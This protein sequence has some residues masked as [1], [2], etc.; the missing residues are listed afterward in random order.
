MTENTTLKYTPLQ[1]IDSK[2]R[3]ANEYFHEKQLKL[4]KT[5]SPRKADLKIRSL[6]LKKLYYAIK[7]HEQ[8]I[9][10]AMYRDFHRSPTETTVLEI[11][12]VYNAILHI[13]DRLHIW[14]APKRIRDNSSPAFMFSKIVIEKIARGSALIIGPFNFPFFLSLLPVAYAISAGNSVILK[15]SELV[16]SC[17]QLLEEILYDADF[18]QGMVQV[19]QG[20]IPET[21]SLVQSGRFDL[22]FFTGAPKTGSIIAQEAAKSLTPCVLELGGKSPAFITETLE[23]KY[24]ETT[25]KRLFFSSFGNSGQI[26]VSPDYA[27]VHESKYSEVVDL[28]KK[29]LQDFFP[30]I[31]ESVEYSHMVNEKAYNEVCKKLEST[32]GTK[33]TSGGQTPEKLDFFI[34]PTLVFDVDWN[35]SLMQSEN[36]AP[37][38]PFIKY[39]D[40][41][42]TIERLLRSCDTPL[43]QYIFSG[44]DQEIQHILSRVRSG[45]CVVGDTLIHVGITDAPF[46]G[47]GTSGYGSSGGI[48]GF[49]A[50]SHER[51]ILKQPFLVERLLS[52]RYPPASSFR[53]SILRVGMERKPWFDRTG[54]NN[55]PFLRSVVISVLVLCF[56]VCF[57]SYKS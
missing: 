21:E 50:F 38:L 24:L 4:S 2:I 32:K 55:I 22:I 5:P 56:S 25:L 37:I 52:M 26:C 15:P 41:D 40:L 6:Q 53:R 35:D 23:N 47:I 57:Y 49:N 17:A 10:D 48:Y 43:A 7:N 16:P 39:R 54:K 29:I 30:R 14:M 18:P 33:F 31:D 19:V 12:P 44:S 42:D 11:I 27:L 13:I 28:A 8:D 45:G 34:P 36:F 9:L 3:L 46:G 20:S 1:E 51:T